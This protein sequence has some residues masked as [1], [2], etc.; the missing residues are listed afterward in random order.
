MT[1]ASHTDQELLPLALIGNDALTRVAAPVTD[2]RDDAIRTLIRNMFHTMRLER[3]CGLAAPQVRRNVR[4]IVMEVDGLQY[5]MINPEIIKRS[6]QMVSFDEGCLSIPN[7]TARI[8]RN[9]HVTVRYSDEMG[10][11]RV[12]D[13]RDFLSVVCQ[14]EIDHLDGILMTERYAT[15]GA[16][17]EQYGII[18]DTP[19]LSR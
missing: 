13:A 14:H 3:G 17:R 10:T 4:V 5:A 8:I 18:D 2:P 16:L 7:T 11:T 12:L 9:E 1:T 15:Q 6:K 19:P